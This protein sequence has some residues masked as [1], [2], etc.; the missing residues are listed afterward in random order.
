MLA[1]FLSERSN[2]QLRA[3]IRALAAYGD[4]AAIPLIE[5]RAN[6]GLHFVRS[7]VRSALSQLG[8]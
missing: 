2:G 1:S 8:R 4:K 5:K 6:H 7:D 3:A